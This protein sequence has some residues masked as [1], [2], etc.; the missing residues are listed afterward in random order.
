MK[1]LTIKTAFLFV[2]GFEHLLFAE[3]TLPECSFFMVLIS[4]KNTCSFI[5]RL[6]KTKCQCCTEML[7]FRKML[8]TYLMDGP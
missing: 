7:V 4:R 6:F 5:H 8:R 2:S 3:F 1:K